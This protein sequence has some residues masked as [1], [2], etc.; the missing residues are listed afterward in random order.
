MAL[1]T[2]VLYLLA[3]FGLCYFIS[4]KIQSET[5]YLVAGRRFPLAIVSISLF[6]TWFGAETCIGSSGAVF[7]EGLSG[8]RA[9]PFGYSLCLIL[10]GLLIAGRIW[11]KRYLTLSDFYLERYGRNVEQLA[12]WILSLSSLIWAAAQLRAF[13][14]VISATTDLNMDLTL[15]IGFVFVV[16]YTL[17]GGLIG[18]MITDVIQAGVIAIGLLCLII[19]VIYHTPDIGGVI[20]SIPQDRL[21]L[22]GEEESWWA[23]LDRWAIPVFGSLVAQEIVARIFAARSKKVAVQACYTSAAIYLGLGAI[24]VFLGLIGPQLLQL[25]GDSEQFLIELA[26]AHLSPLF[27]GVFSGALISA[28]LAT[29]DSILLSVGALVGHNF[30]IPRMKIRGEKAKLLVSRMV[31]FAS[32]LFAYILALHS[33]GIYELLEIAS[34]FGTAGILVITLVGLWSS[35]GNSHAALAALIVGIFTTPLAEYGFDAESPF[36]ISIAAAALAFALGSLWKPPKSP[37]GIK[38]ALPRTHQ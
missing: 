34:S 28:L 13:G 33:T 2:L 4:K 30:L 6:A 26:K 9:D 19:A 18:D 20:S 14:Q 36:L 32:G 31:V 5:D 37:D 23:R 17:L 35:M 3:Q 1:V 15:I 10:S 11:N 25:Q 8:S 12:V 24:P 22:L 21:S 29:I 16:S 27:V 7:T 38:S